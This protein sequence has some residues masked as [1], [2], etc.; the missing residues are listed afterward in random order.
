MVGGGLM[1]LLQYGAQDIYLLYPNC[2]S[3]P[4][5]YVLINREL[6]VLSKL[7]KFMYGFFII[8]DEND[9][10]VLHSCA[11]KDDT[12]IINKCDKTVFRWDSK[13]IHDEEIFNEIPSN[14]YGK[15]LYC[16]DTTHNKIYIET[17]K[18]KNSVKTKIEYKLCGIADAKCYILPMNTSTIKT[19]NKTCIDLYCFTTNNNQKEYVECYDQLN[20]L[21]RL[22]STDDNIYKIKSSDDELVIR[23]NDHYNVYGDSSISYKNINIKELTRTLNTSNILYVLHTNDMLFDIFD[24]E[25]IKKIVIDHPQN[26]QYI[27]RQT[28]ELCEIVL[29]QNPKNI[30]YINKNIDEQAMLAYKYNIKALQYIRKRNKI[31]DDVMNTLLLNEHSVKYLQLCRDMHHKALALNGLSLQHMK[32]Q[33][34][35]KCL[36][37]VRQNCLA[38]QYVKHQTKRIQD[39]AK[40]LIK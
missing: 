23:V 37:A 12:Y 38:L 17:Y 39:E 25:T 13:F 21:R 22:R 7:S 35:E 4:I 24:F 36:I 10:F 34:E 32:H 1:Q 20:I 26:I 6:V 8:T 9:K 18:D 27:I 29:T 31:S 2:S 14:Y 11:N 16:V 15:L 5:E 19:F 33:T 28:D 40:I 30:K 3:K